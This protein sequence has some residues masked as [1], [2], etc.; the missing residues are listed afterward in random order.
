LVRLGQQ[1]PRKPKDDET[2]VKYVV[3]NLVSKVAR[4]LR[5]ERRSQANKEGEA[6]NDNQQQ[7]N[8][9]VSQSQSNNIQRGNGRRGRG[10]G[11]YANQGRTNFKNFKIN[12]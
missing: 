8:T 5:K 1:Q 11:Y 10:R 7:D 3:R 4:N 2:I 6:D 12:S 9:G